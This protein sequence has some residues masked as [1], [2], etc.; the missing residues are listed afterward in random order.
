MNRRALVVAACLLAGCTT[1]KAVGDGALDA[2]STSQ[3][4]PSTSS[5]ST[6]TTSTSTTIPPTTTTVL[7]QFL[8]EE[9]IGTSVEGRPITV[10]HRGT[11]GGVVV[12]VVG[13]IHGNEDAGLAILDHL[14]TLPIPEGIDLW[15]MPAINPDGYAN[16]ARGNSN[17]V[18]LN[19]NF[20]HDWTAIAEPGDWQYSGTGG[21][22]E[23]E[24]QAF[25]D[26][27]GR[28]HPALTLWYHQD[29]HTISPS[30]GRDAALRRHYATRTGLDQTVV[31]GGTYTGVAATWVRRAMPDTMSF[32]IELGPTLSPDEAL[33]H[34]TVVLEVAAMVPAV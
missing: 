13:V 5:T 30:K 33:L 7:P 28:L 20:P 15:I 32:I 27:A 1:T 34:A 23:P 18:D 12:L 26:L 6:S 25:M 21:G 29:L 9:T 24:T 3:A 14:R 8:G 10:F 19:R 4:G 22:S 11:P 17:G 31:S 16:Q 2:T